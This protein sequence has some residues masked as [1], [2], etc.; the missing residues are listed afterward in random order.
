MKRIYKKPLWIQKHLARGNTKCDVSRFS[1]HYSFYE[2]R[3]GSYDLL[4]LILSF[5]T[6]SNVKHALKCL[7]T[8]VLF[9]SFLSQRTVFWRQ[10]TLLRPLCCMKKSEFFQQTKTKVFRS[11][12]SRKKVAYMMIMIWPFLL[13]SSSLLA[14]KSAYKPLLF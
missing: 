5:T 13:S 12:E 1:I 11:R 3:K 8:V 9:G 7:C 4:S 2:A 10:N 6:A 14:L